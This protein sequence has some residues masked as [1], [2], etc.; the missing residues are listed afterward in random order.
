MR[1][2]VSRMPRVTG[3]QGGI[4][5]PV[6]VDAEPFGVDVRQAPASSDD[7][8]ERDRFSTQRFQFGDRLAGPCDRESFAFRGAV[9]HVAA[10]VAQFTNR[11]L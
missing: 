8:I 5:N 7:H 10:V 2:L 6:E 11:D 1:V 4:E 3:S 9:D